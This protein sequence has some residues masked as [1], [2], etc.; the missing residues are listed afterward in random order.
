MS[1]NTEIVHSRFLNL[2]EV[3]DFLDQFVKAYYVIPQYTDISYQ[4]IIRSILRISMDII[5]HPVDQSKRSTKFMCD[6]GEEIQLC[7]I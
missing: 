6:I 7:L 1:F 4:F 2:A 5:P 3:E